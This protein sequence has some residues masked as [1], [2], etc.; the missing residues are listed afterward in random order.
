MKPV[1]LSY[2]NKGRANAE[3]L[4]T[5]L[6]EE[7][8]ET[9]MDNESIQAGEQWQN[10]LQSR[11]HEASAVLFLIGPDGQ[12]SEEQRNEAAAVFRS[13]W[14]AQPKIP[15][16]PVVTG[17]PELPPF[18]K[19]VPAIKVEDPKQGWSEAAQTIKRSLSGAP[20]IVSTPSSAGENEQKA[21]LL[22]I[23]EFADSLR[24][25]SK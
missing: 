14:E 5:A 16:I 1:F 18:L 15:L 7:G 19:Q 12:V 25:T 13:E 8:I 22:E 9:F 21:R 6:K 4:R 20:G 23:R 3:R 10:A 11:I 17:D 2:A 24:A